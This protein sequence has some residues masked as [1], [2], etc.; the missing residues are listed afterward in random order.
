[1]KSHLHPRESHPNPLLFARRSCSL[2]AKAHISYSNFIGFFAATTTASSA[3]LSQSRVIM[4]LNGSSKSPRG[5]G[6]M[7]ISSP[8]IDCKRSDNE[9]ILR[10]NCEKRRKLGQ[11]GP[12]KLEGGNLSR[13]ILTALDKKSDRSWAWQSL[14][15]GT[16][17]TKW[18]RFLCENENIIHWMIQIW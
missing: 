4:V 18:D 10:W 6:G 11:G 8:R 3:K 2:S 1:M 5:G 17:L 7:D 13:F 15:S 12:K 14:K 16:A 9:A